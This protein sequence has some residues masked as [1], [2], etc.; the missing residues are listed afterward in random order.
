M[1]DSMKCHLTDC[2]NEV[3]HEATKNWGKGGTIH[4]CSEHVPGAGL[5]T[6]SKAVQDMAAAGNWYTVRPLHSCSVE[7]CEAVGSVVVTQCGT[8]SYRQCA[9]HAPGGKRGPAVR[10]V[11]PSNPFDFSSYSTCVDGKTEHWVPA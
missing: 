8:M 6:A 2:H 10:P 5:A 1:T 7:G 9:D 3:T 4:T 11:N